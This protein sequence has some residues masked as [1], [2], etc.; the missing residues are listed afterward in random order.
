M[1]LSDLEIAPRYVAYLLM[2]VRDATYLLVACIMRT[3][4]IKASFVQHLW[5]CLRTNSIVHLAPIMG[6][7]CI[8]NPIIPDYFPDGPTQ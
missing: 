5:Y 7:C 3:H 4:N 8:N 6:Y 1:K 2:Q